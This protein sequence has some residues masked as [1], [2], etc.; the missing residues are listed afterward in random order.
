MNFEVKHKILLNLDKLI[1]QELLTQE[2]ETLVRYNHLLTNIFSDY[3]FIDKLA[4]MTPRSWRYHATPFH[5]YNHP[6]LKLFL[7]NTS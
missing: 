3:P 6:R 2:N 5:C 1:Q 7:A 4:Y